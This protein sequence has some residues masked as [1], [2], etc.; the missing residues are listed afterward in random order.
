MYEI[1][2]RYDERLK[3]ALTMITQAIRHILRNLKLQTD[4]MAERD[5]KSTSSIYKT[6]I[7]VRSVMSVSICISGDWKNKTSDSS[8]D[9]SR[10]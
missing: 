2:V 4:Y 10:T 5:T 3:L 8:L 1:N 9:F 6:V 7:T